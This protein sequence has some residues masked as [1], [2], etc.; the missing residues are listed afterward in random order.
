MNHIPYTGCP[1]EATFVT[2]VITS[3]SIHY[4]KLYDDRNVGKE[5]LRKAGTGSECI[6]DGNTDNQ[7]E[8]GHLF[9]RH[10]IGPVP[11]YAEDGKQPQGKPDLQADA[12]KQ[13]TEQK[14]D[15]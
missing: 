6:D 3:Y 11:Y 13:V 9:N 15:T 5:Y 4:T 12:L 1:V 2:G 8:I 7:E 10:R 14:N